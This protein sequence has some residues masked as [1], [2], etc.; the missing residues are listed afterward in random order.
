MGETANKQCTN[1]RNKYKLFDSTQNPLT[2]WGQQQTSSVPTT[3]T[4]ISFSKKKLAIFQ[5][6]TKVGCC[7]LSESTEAI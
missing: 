1:N 4:S 2:Q 5:H 3:E 7:L 6:F